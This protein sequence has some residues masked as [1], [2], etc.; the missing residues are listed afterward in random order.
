MTSMAL[1]D[2]IRKLTYEDYVRIPDDGRRHEIIDGEHYVTAAPF[3]PHAD[4][5][6]E[7][8]AQLRLFVRRH[9]LG[10]VYHAPCDVLLSEHD[11]VQ[12]DVLFV[13]NARARI[14]SDRK[15]VKGAPDLVIEI[16][17]KSTRRLDE[18]TKLDLYDRYDV[19]E[20][21]IVDPDRRTV[22]AYRRV[23]E[24]LRLSSEIS[25]AAGDALTSPLLPGFSL[26]L[27]AVFEI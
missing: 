8:A 5:S 7:L 25:A 4:V 20:Y 27:A 12:P 16:L 15:N 26:P 24:G 10:R 13:S 21:W 17:S 11:V 6:T 1:H 23:A 19:L 18:E 3:L 9:R 14:L 2:R 22:Q